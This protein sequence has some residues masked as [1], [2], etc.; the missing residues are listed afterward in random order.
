MIGWIIVIIA[1]V[2]GIVS[3]LASLNRPQPGAGAGG[4]RGAGAN[5]NPGGRG[6]PTTSE[7]DRFLEEVNRRKQQQQDRRSVPP[8]QREPQRQRQVVVERPIVAKPARQQQV[9]MAEPVVPVIIAEPVQPQQRIMTL[10]QLANIQ[11]PP[12]LT[13]SVDRPTLKAAKAM[14]GTPNGLRSV[15]MLNEILG[16]PR[17]RK[18]FRRIGT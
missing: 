11:V 2:V 5:N 12:T 13:Q 14:L 18:P 15:F 9:I 4:G 16:P 17:C 10:N 8:V 1:V 3:H 7:I 6:R